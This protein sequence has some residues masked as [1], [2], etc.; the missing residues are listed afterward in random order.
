[1]L[2][3][4]EADSLPALGEALLQLEQATPHS[5]V[6]AG[7]R[8]LATDLPPAGGGAEV[9]LLAGRLAPAQGKPADAERLFRAAAA[10]RPRAPRRRPSWRWLS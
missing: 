6:G 5:A 3:P 8:R 10:A 9:R 1:M 2:Q 4:I 7:S